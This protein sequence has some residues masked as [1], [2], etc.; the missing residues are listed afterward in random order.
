MKLTPGMQQYMDQKKLYPDCVILFRMGDFYETF[1]D[2]AKICSKVLGIT[3]T[4]RGKDETRA[5][6]A[7]IPYHALDNYLH[8]LVTAGYKVAI[9]EQ[10]EDP[11]LTKKL[12]KRGVTRV[13]TAGTVMDEKCLDKG[14]NNY[15]ASVFID[16]NKFGFSVCDIS[17]G[18]FLTSEFEN[19]DSL[20]CEFAKFSP[21]ELLI[22][23]DDEKIKQYC[24]ANHIFYNK[25]DIT[26]FWIESCE[27]AVLEQF[28]VHSISSLGLSEHELSICS[29]GALLNYLKET[30]M[31]NLSHINKL[32]YYVQSEFMNLDASTIRNLELL[33]NIMDGTKRGSLLSVIDK[34]TTALGSRLIRNWITR[35]LLDVDKINKRL[36]AVKAFVSDSQTRQEIEQLLKSISDI[37]RIMGRIEYGIAN[38]RDLIALKNSLL[39]IPKINEHLKK[40][41]SISNAFGDIVCTHDFSKLTTLLLEAIKDEPALSTRE[42]NMIKHNYHKELDELFAIKRDGAKILHEIEKKEKEETKIPSLKIGYNNVFGYY[43]EVTSK[44][45]D[46]VPANY[47]R[48]QTLSNYERYITDELKQKEEQI[49]SADEKIVELEYKLFLEVIEKTKEF[50][51]QIQ[52]AATNIATIDC[53]LSFAQVSVLNHYTMPVV[54]RNYELKLIDARHPVIETM[55]KNYISNDCTLSLDKNIMIITG[56]NM[57]GKSS[58]MRQVALCALLS[59]IGCF[60]PAKEAHIGVIDRIFTRVGAYDDLTSGQSTFMVEMNETSNIINNATENSII[61]LD[62]IGRGTSTYDGIA[63][64]WSVAEHI[65]NVI[66]AKCLFATHYHQMNKLS[67]MYDNV[68]NFNVAVDENKEGIVFL[69]KLIEGGTDKSYGI[70]VARLAGLPKDVIDNAKKIMSRLEL[71]DEIADKIAAPIKP[72][73]MSQ[74]KESDTKYEKQTKLL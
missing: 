33:K 29:S 11:K 21:K 72:K 34:T 23:Q 14:S 24:E 58:F 4:A 55:Q 69:H 31:T 63:I 56:P 45:K 6:L 65:I 67:Q 5:P 49:L 3:L 19:Y 66:G 71:E 22:S 47:V 46:Q 44:Y 59:Q 54:S 39:T 27:K 12:V 28:N 40:N 74:L 61:I 37:E 8:K 36:F 30:Q 51:K 64:A 15:I 25:Q 53:V 50:T 10:L 26:K 20:I 52:D 60:V 42:G 38:A 70:E 9:C 73:K 18:E 57:S 1:Y 48:K 68:A 32:R 17:T 62:E 13:V 16:E 2:D 41:E 7:G 35:P 43:I